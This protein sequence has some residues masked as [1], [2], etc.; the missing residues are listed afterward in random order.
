[1]DEQI[2]H[3]GPQ[4]G[5]VLARLVQISGPFSAGQIRGDL[6]DRFHVALIGHA[7]APSLDPKSAEAPAI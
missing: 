4:F 2:L 1:V 6:K 7:P 3:L 5:A